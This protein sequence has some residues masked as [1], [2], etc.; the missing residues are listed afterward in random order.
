MA[1]VEV[2]TY[3]DL[4]VL[5]Y[6]PTRTLTLRNAFVRAMNKRFNKLI[7]V[8]RKAIV[9]DD[10]FGLSIP[11][12]AEPVSP[13]Y[14]AFAFQSYAKKVESFIEWLHEQE[15]KGILELVQIPRIG[16]SIEEPW[17]N[18]YIEDSYKR[19]VIRA[20]AE[21]K[22]A[23]YDVPTIEESGGISA[24][25]NGA[26]H[27]E[28]AGLL[29]TRMYQ[30]LKGITAAMETQISAVLAQGMIDGDSAAVLSRKLIAAINGSGVGDLG[31]TDT[32]GRFIPAQRRARMLVRTEVIRAHHLANIQ[33]Y[34]NWRVMNI[35]V[36]AEWGTAGDERVCDICAGMHGNRYTLE[37]IRHM[38]PVHPNCR[39]IAIP[40]K[41]SQ[42]RGVSHPTKP[43]TDELR[44]V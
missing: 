16:T 7:Q 25:F 3:S 26:F 10:C 6:D 42:A 9:E 29:F 22:K 39:C 11:T 5:Q 18:Y 44:N 36:V 28:G 1:I 2:S 27:V 35:Y 4:Q 13:G 12:Y 19:G 30:E 21:M 8:V 41:R 17:T 15:E 38:I 32:L 20:R 34:M 24:V 14:R 33:E 31:I 23:G 37:E 43:R 40:V